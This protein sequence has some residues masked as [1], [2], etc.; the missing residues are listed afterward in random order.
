MIVRP[1]QA[2]DLPAIVSIVER[3]NIGAEGI[4][5]SQWTGIVL[6]AVRQAQIVGFIS[7]M[8]GKPYAIITEIGVLPEHQKGRA[9]HMLIK[10]MELLLRYL[11]CPAWAAYVREKNTMMRSVLENLESMRSNE[12]G[13][14]YHQSL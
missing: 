11:G 6:V 2:Q 12:V 5:Y 3:C 14:M 9:C 7:A 1:A 4:D 8:P 10:S 13:Y